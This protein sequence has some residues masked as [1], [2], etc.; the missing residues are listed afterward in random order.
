MSSQ[1][2]V[3]S[4]VDFVIYHLTL[5]VTCVINEVIWGIWDQH[6]F[7]NDLKNSSCNDDKDTS[8]WNKYHASSRL[9][10]RMYEEL[11]E[12]MLAIHKL[13]QTADNPGESSASDDARAA[14][15]DSRDEGEDDKWTDLPDVI[16]EN[17]FTRLSYKDRHHASQVCSR[18][19]AAFYAPKVWETFTLYSGTLTRQVFKTGDVNQ[20]E[21]SARKAQLCLGRVGYL[22]KNMTITAID[23]FFD[24]YEFIRILIQFILHYDEFPLP[25]L[26]TF[27]F[28]FA[29]EFRGLSGVI[30]H[31]TGG[32][33][34][35]ILKTLLRNLQNLKHLKLRQLLLD[36]E[37]VSGLFDAV[38]NNLE[39]TLESMEI[40]NCTKIPFP[41]FELCRFSSL[42]QLTITTQ[43]LNDDIV[44][45]LGLNGLSRLVI[46]Q[47]R[48]TAVAQPVSRECWG[49]LK[50]VAPLLK[51][52]LE[53]RGPAKHDLLIQPRAPVDTIIV[54]S[55]YSK[56]SPAVADSI[57]TNYQDT[58]E[59]VLQKSLPRIHG[60]RSFH[61]RNDVCFLD[62]VRRC[63][64]LHTLAIR[65]RISTATVL[66][67]AKGGKSLKSLMLRENAL[68]K[69][70][71]WP[72]SPEWSDQFYQWLKKSSTSFELTNREVSNI[73]GYEWK[74]LKDREFKQNYWWHDVN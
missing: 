44:L 12:F 39:Y 49:H 4:I 3:S 62:F 31:G 57:V 51:V 64:K 19:N 41:V 20:K 33:I 53:L 30:I 56:M 58:L 54:S 72:K 21:L 34:L 66:L 38:A 52:T 24:V 48:Y 16:L 42:S 23:N 63:S 32:K 74:P 27:D 59:A 2:I 70:C 43:H 8:L 50:E 5:Y 65:E 40:L 13:H 9:I 46:V 15:H 47:D 1:L 14:G 29:C 37:E 60:S 18:W 25:L 35:E 28:T 7:A 71:D 69:K 17:I 22:I 6:I 55:P 45:E 68:L 73:F 67:L 36:T 26:H 11:F 61:D 10:I